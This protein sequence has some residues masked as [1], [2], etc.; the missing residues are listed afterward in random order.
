VRQLPFSHGKTGRGIWLQT[1]GEFLWPVQIRYDGKSFGFDY[2]I[3]AQIKGKYQGDITQ[4]YAQYYNN[5][6]NSSTAR[7]SS[8]KFQYY[9]RALL[10]NK[11]GDWYIKDRRLNI[12]AAIDFAFSLRKKA[13]YSALVVI[14]VDY[15]GNYYVLDIDRFKTE[16]IVDYFNHILKAQQKWGFRKIRAEV[17][18][19]Q[20]AIVGEL[21]ESYIKPNGVPLSIDEFRP[22][23]HQGDK[24]ERINAVLEPK[25]DN[26]QVWHYRGGNCQSLEEELVMLHPP[27]DDIK[28]ALANAISISNIPRHINQQGLVSNVITHS[29]FGGVSYA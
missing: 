4:F 10:I 6:N 13:D 28:D 1:N 23:R 9:E 21:K 18:I 8:E 7:I 25:Y 20:Q 5:P 27:H 11:E 14:G 22:N 17:T 15:L 26:M 29:R 2:K 24:D 19:A 12:Y 3:L 16:R